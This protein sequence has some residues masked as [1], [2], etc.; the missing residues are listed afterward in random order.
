M[1]DLFFKCQV[2]SLICMTTLSYYREVL[3]NL[4]FDKSQP[5][6]GLI[7]SF[8]QEKHRIQSQK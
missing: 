8:A 1:Y 4:E 5:Q 7:Q 6:F 2:I 3:G